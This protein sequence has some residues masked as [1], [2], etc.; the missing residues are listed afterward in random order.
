MDSRRAVVVL[1]IA[2]AAYITAILQRTSLSVA[3][4]VATDRFSVDATALSS[5]AV[6]QL[7]V[8]ALLQ[9]PVGV[10]V[11]RFG[12]RAL[13]GIGAIVM[14][15]GQIVLAVAPD[16]G[17]AVL[18][19]ILVGAGD[20]MTFISVL[21]LLG[22]WF[23]PRR[24]PVLSQWVGTLGQSGQLLS[25]VPLG[26]VLATAGWQPAFL[27]LASISVVV[28]AAVLLAVRDAPP[29]AERGRAA[30]LRIALR[31]LR[32]ALR[33]PGT[34]LAF[35]AHA[36]TG[37]PG[38]VLVML[39]GFPALSVGLGYGPA[40]ASA[41]LSIVVVAGA[42][43][44]PVIGLLSA[45]F[46]YRRSSI[47]LGIVAVMG[48]AWAVVLLWPDR[49]PLAAIVVLLVVI[50]VGG[51]GSLI[52]FD[53]ARTFNP[54]PSQGAASGFVNVGGFSISVVLLLGI[55]LV[56]DALSPGAEPAALYAW[57]NWRPAFALQFPVIAA[58]LIPLLIARRRTRRRLQEEEGIAVAPLWV[59]I[60]RRRRARRS[61]KPVR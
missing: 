44:G 52:G 9:I 29:G 47:V 45:R 4:V 26:A 43:I 15:S 50:A 30:T 61:R 6:L 5:L 3:G 31:Q 19:R 35:W 41:L 24:L 10:L 25:A 8:Y 55:G 7:L 22:H 49:P 60:V 59:A 28:A 33:R 58:A 40:L 23:S 2:G 37:S 48:A 57:E 53:F 1:V 56:L 12:P 32:D 20:A 51:P 39:W 13:I 36:V 11:D 16:I 42:L 21:R 38:T 14:A 18:G 27:G 46:P 54:G 17:I 34:R